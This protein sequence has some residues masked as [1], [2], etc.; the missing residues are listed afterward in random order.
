MV[1]PEKRILNWKIHGY[2]SKRPKKEMFGDYVKN[3][4]FKNELFEE[5][6]AQAC[7]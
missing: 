3:E 4:N 7:L 5:I 6:V 2:K 1:S